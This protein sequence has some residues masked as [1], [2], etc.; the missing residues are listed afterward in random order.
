MA[1]FDIKGAL[2]GKWKAT[3]VDKGAMEAFLKVKAVPMLIAKALTLFSTSGTFELKTARG[4][5]VPTRV[6]PTA[7]RFADRRGDRVPPRDRRPPRAGT[8][9]S[10]RRSS[11]CSRT[12]ST[13]RS[14]STARR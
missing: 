6:S 13:P 5:R 14:R 8:T 3:E 7:A 10:S 12:R 11:A 2:A 9:S 4:A 1:A